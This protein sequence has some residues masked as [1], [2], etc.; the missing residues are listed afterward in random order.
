MKNWYICFI[1]ILTVGC[2]TPRGIP[3]AIPNFD[4]VDG[5]VYRSGQPN[6]FGFEMLKTLGIK[7]VLNLRNDEQSDE[8]DIVNSLGM[9]YSHFP[10]KGGHVCSQ[11]TLQTI[12]ILIWDLPKPVLV[13]CEFGCDRT[14]VVIACYRLGKGF[15]PWAAWADAKQHGASLFFGSKGAI[16]DYYENFIKTKSLK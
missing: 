8:Q 10:L 3:P 9:T 1:L 15:T 14:G 7:S 13:H 12:Q 16:N 2:F 11:E 5:V 6:L 4:K